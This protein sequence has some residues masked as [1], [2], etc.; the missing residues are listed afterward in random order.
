MKKTLILAAVP[1]LFLSACTQYPVPDSS[2]PVPYIQEEAQ[3]HL[4]TREPAAEGFTRGLWLPYMEYAGIMYGKSEEEF[5]TAVR[6]RFSAAKAQGINTVYLHVHPCGDAYY[7]SVVF[8]SGTYLDGDYD[9]LAVMTEE[10]RASDISPH[11]WINPLRCQTTEQM[12]E[13]PESFIIRRMTDNGQAKPV[14]DRWYL[15]PS[16]PEVRQLVCDCAAE[17]LDGYDIDGIHIDD[18][19]YPTTDPEWDSAE[20]AFSGASDLARWRTDNITVMVKALYDTVKAHDSSAEFSVSPQGNITADYETQYADVRLWGGT[21]GYCD[22]IIP[23][24]YY[25]FLN[26]TCP[27]EETLRQWE[28]IVSGSGVR[29]VVGLAAYKQGAE[30][31]WAGA[32]GE[33]EWIDDP[34]V[35]DR[36]KVLTEQSTADGWALYE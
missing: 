3:L 30:D 1:A 24:I 32:A 22:T 15:D 7:R 16:Y 31:R 2:R 35:I 14:G 19:F 27:F 10:A 21:E 4:D 13:L 6:E 23:Q 28:E 5:R 20:F 29:L 8:P 12:Q 11:A 25:G 36:Q 9:P 18:Y 26:E 33:T 17:L 34:G